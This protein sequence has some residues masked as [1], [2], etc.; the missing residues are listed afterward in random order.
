MNKT[1]SALLA[2]VM[3]LSLLLS[4]ACA[5]P[6]DSLTLRFLPEN[7]NMSKYGHMALDMPADEFLR[8]FELGDI[9]TVT[10]PGCEPMDV[11]VCASYDDVSVG[12]MLLRVKSGEDHILLAVNYGKMGVLLG[13]LEDAPKDAGVN[14][15]PREGADFD[16]PVTVEQKEKGGWLDRLQLSYLKRGDEI[17]DYEADLSEEQF[18]NFR[19]IETTG[20]GKDIL[21]RSSSPIRDSMNRNAYADRCCEAAGIR[22][23]VNLGDTEAEAMALEG[24]SDT[25]YSRQNILFLGLPAAFDTEQF[26]EGLAE[27]FRFIIVNEGPYL[28][29]CTEG[30]DRAGYT[31]AVLELLMGAS[32]DEAADDYLMTYENYFAPLAESGEQLN[33]ELRSAIRGILIGNLNYGYGIENIEAVDPAQATQDYLRMIGLTEDEIAA[34]KAALSANAE[35]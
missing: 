31:G 28:V 34:L 12:E 23:C 30:K 10:V 7:D 16:V 19:V 9:V 14:Y 1:I 17:T 2:L 6:T 27:G 22:T 29:H 35:E 11:P 4:A 5:E 32:L 21:Y 20:M 13:M 15:I 24:Y 25:Y 3:A 18:A 26:R 8:V 33:D